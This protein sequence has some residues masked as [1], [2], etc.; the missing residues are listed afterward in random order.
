MCVDGGLSFA[1]SHCLGGGEGSS[2]ECVGGW[3]LLLSCTCTVGFGKGEV[4]CWLLVGWVGL[5]FCFPTYLFHVGQGREEHLG[6]LDAVLER[7]IDGGTGLVD[8]GA[9]K[10]PAVQLRQAR[11]L[12]NEL[13]GLGGSRGSGR[14]RSCGWRRGGLLGAPVPKKGLH[15][16]QG[17]EDQHEEEDAAAGGRRHGCV[18]QGGARVRIGSGVQG[19]CKLGCGWGGG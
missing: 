2:G 18:G 1:K 13:H 5:R 16:G 10:P 11:A 7:G 19:R 12:V 4:G 9:V 6:V 8:Q 3:G 15:A 17:E 14:R